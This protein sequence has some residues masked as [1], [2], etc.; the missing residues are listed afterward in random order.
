MAAG[1]H[2][3]V[4]IRGHIPELPRPADMDRLSSA[5]RGR[6]VLLNELLGHRPQDTLRPLSPRLNPE[7]RTVRLPCTEILQAAPVAD[8]S[9]PWEGG[10]SLM[11][12]RHRA[13]GRTWVQAHAC[14]S[15]ETDNHGSGFK[16]LE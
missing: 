4:H 2:V 12:L 16:A 1:G 10:R 9:S 3:R 7:A 11:F 6:L 15:M 13:R 14:L 5:E 8:A